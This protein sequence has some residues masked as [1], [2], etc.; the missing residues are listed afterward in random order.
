MLKFERQVKVGNTESYKF[1][2]TNWASTEEV[3]SFSVSNDD[4]LLTVV[5]TEFDNA[6]L[7]FLVTGASVGTAIVKISFTTAT[8]S[9]CTNVE[10]DV[11]EGC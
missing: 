7:R 11:I 6:K 9:D 5:A 2:V 3:L 4:N 1:N 10:I 8:R